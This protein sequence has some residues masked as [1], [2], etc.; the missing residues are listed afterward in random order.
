VNDRLSTRWVLLRGLIA[1]GLL[2]CGAK[3][4]AGSSPSSR[5]SSLDPTGS[6][7]G[8]SCAPEGPG[9]AL[10][11]Y[12]WDPG[13]RA[14]V[15]TTAVDGVVVVRYE[16]H[17]CDVLLEVLGRCISHKSHYGYQNSPESRRI[18]AT[19]RFEI[20]ARFPVAQSR[21]HAEIDRYEALRAD[22]Q[23]HGTESVADGTVIHKSDLEG[24]C[25]GATHVISAIHRGAFVLS[26]GQTEEM[27]AQ[28]VLFDAEQRKRI[29]VLDEAGNPSLC[30]ANRNDLVPGCD[31]PLALTLTA[32]GERFGDAASKLKSCPTDMVAVDEG[33]FAMGCHNGA[34]NERPVHETTVAPYC[35]DRDEVT[36]GE[37]QACVQQGACP[38]LSGACQAWQAA[39]PDH[40]QACVN[41]DE[42]TRFCGSRGRRL[43]TEAEWEF[44][45]RGGT[46]GWPYPVGIL[47]PGPGEACIGRSGSCVVRSFR[48]ESMNLHDLSGNVREWTSGF[49]VDYAL[50]ARR[51]P[52]GALTGTTVVARGGSFRSSPEDTRGITRHVVS[53]A[54]SPEI[55]FRCVSSR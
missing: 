44:A 50:H 15:A 39:S 14:K 23:R 51:N 9:E 26:A 10:G 33:T 37:Y 4:P 13:S 35:I 52:A 32:L 3:G 47:E 8:V 21:L 19:S 43:P 2:G 55:G 31:I 49:Y 7:Q 28:V 30:S 34:P 18:V 41:P 42:A 1:L 36:S 16:R 54:G 29:H 45:A 38:R 40:P 11:I 24:D 22:T 20:G 5:P 48:P 12:G 17:G 25:Q 53:A 46:D 27:T 6:P